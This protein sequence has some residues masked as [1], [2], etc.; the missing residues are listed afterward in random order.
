MAQGVYVL[1]VL[2]ESPS[3]LTEL[4]WWLCVVERRPIA[5]VEV[6]ATGRGARF[7][8]SLATGD[9]WR[10]LEAST[11]PLPD[12]QPEGTPPDAA[13]GFRIHRF[14]L[15]ESVL[16][17]VRSEP[18]SAAVSGILHDRVRTLRAALGDHIQLVG[19]L[20]G[21]RKTVSG[22]LQT[23]F[24]LQAGPTDR[25]VHV[26]LH[27]DLESSL[28][29]EGRMAEYVS[30]QQRW[31]DLSGVAGAEQIVVYDAPFPRIKHLVRRRLADALERL[32]WDEVWPVLDANAGRNPTATLTRTTFQ[33][34]TY[35]IR[36]AESAV[37]LYE[38][39]LGK[40]PGAVLAAMALV[41]AGSTAAD[42]IAWL[43]ENEVGWRPSSATG[44]TPETRE[45][46]IRS[47]VSTLRG[48]FDDIPVGLERF[49]PPVQ[50]FSMHRV[51]VDLGSF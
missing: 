30:P 13:H 28:R 2:G 31:T 17:D 25:L 16:D 34:W 36:D 11:G 51:D 26:L 8:R 6:W 45:P 5:G 41:G 42:L 4:L 14:R 27:P 3:V 38:V 44:N 7:V 15:G 48:K 40:R 47:A 50:G 9:A 20:A 29:D 32:S 21:G 19:S 23:A 49:A 24:C 33:E 1:A 35:T 12:L 46:M 10:S 39:T 22:A 43:D 37:C 18:E